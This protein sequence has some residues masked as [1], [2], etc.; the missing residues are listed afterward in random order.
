MKKLVLSKTKNSEFF[1]LFEY[2]SRILLKSRRDPTK[3]ASDEFII[4]NNIENE[5]K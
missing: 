4:M 5:I 2:L 3:L 1:L